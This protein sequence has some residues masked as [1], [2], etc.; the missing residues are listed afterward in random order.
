MNSIDSNRQFS[1][2]ILYKIEHILKFKTFS[3]LCLSGS[4]IFIK[5]HKR[6]RLFLEC[7]NKDLIS[8]KK[9]KLGEEKVFTNIITKSYIIKLP[10][11]VNNYLDQVTMIN[12]TTWQKRK[13]KNFIG[14]NLIDNIIN[15]KNL[16]YQEVYDT[17][18]IVFKTFNSKEHK[19][20]VYDFYYDKLLWVETFN[21]K[22]LFHSL[23]YTGQSHDDRHFSWLSS[24][25]G[26]KNPFGYI[27]DTI[28]GIKV[29]KLNY[30]VQIPKNI[31]TMTETKAVKLDQDVL[32][33]NVTSSHKLALIGTTIY[34]INK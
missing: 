20:W 5:Y 19:I 11:V 6:N 21:Q 18:I 1:S 25:S 9:L 3:S 4:S 34:Y 31:D 16:S 17:D 10:H 23:G 2:E 28:T 29:L 12:K 33:K 30:D 24:S 22:F 15:D 13:T 8:I 7:F 32:I 14:S 27:I 26:S